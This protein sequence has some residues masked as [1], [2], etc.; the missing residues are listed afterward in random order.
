VSLEANTPAKLSRPRLFDMT[1]RHRLFARLDTGRAH[2]AIW[3]DGPA[4]AGKTSLLAGYVEARAVPACWYQVDGGDADVATFFYY[5]RAL[6]GLAASADLPAFSPEYLGDVPG[7]ARRYFRALFAQ[8]GAS[9]LLVL[10]NVQE[11]TG[12]PAFLA[13]LREAIGQVPAGVNLVLISRWE[14]PTAFAR[15]MALQSIVRIS[16]PELQLTA[17]ETAAIA[18]LDPG[19]DDARIGQLLEACGGWAAGLTLTLA[20]RTGSGGAAPGRSESL[21]AAFD[22]LAAEILDGADP[23]TRDFLLHTWPLPR[24][25]A[26]WARELTGLDGAERILAKL[27]QQNYFIER[28]PAP[29]PS[30]QYHGLFREFLAARARRSLPAEQIAELQRR[31][32]ALLEQAGENSEAFALRQASGEM[33]ECQR[34]I[35]AHA[36]QLAE[37][38][39]LQTLHGWIDALPKERCDNSPWLAY[40]RGICELGADPARARRSFATAADGFA[41]ANERLG[42]SKALAGLIDTCYAEWSD[43]S[44]LDPWIAQ[45]IALLDEDLPFARVEDGLQ[46]VAAALVALLYR[47]PTHP[48]LPELAARVHTRLGG[49]IAANERVAAGTYLLNC[50][51]WMGQ[52]GAAREVIALVSPQLDAAAVAPLR[53]A[54]WSV[55][56]AYHHYIAG[57]RQATLTSLEAAAQIA[58][59]H[60]QAVAENIVLL[61]ATFLHLSEGD[62]AAATQS[63]TAFERQ[64]DPGRRLDYAI[65]TYHRA[66]LALLAG[67]IDAALQFGGK[68]AKLAEQAGVPNVQGYFLLL[69]ALATAERGDHAAAL[70]A[71]TRGHGCT[72]PERFPIFE[73]T[74]QLVRA[75]LASRAA[76]DA[77]CDAALRAALAIGARHDYANNLLWLPG[78]MAHLCARALERN[79][80]TDYVRRLIRRRGLPPPGQDTI[81]WPWPLRISTLGALRVERDGEALPFSRKVQKRPLALLMA[82]VALGGQDISAGLLAEKLWPDAEGDAARAA[83][84]TALYRLRHLLDVD[85][86]ILLADGKLSLNG[87]RVWVDTQ[88]FE[89]LARELTAADHAPAAPAVE[90]LL[91]LYHGHFLE[92][93]E[94]APWMLGRREKLK[95]SLEHVL[96]I[97]G[98]RLE[99]AGQWDLAAQA[100]ERGIGL[101]MLAEPL[102]R[103]LMACQQRQGRPAQ[104]LETYRRCRQALSVVLGIPPSPE[105]EALRRSFD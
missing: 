17:E 52:T 37:Q 38:G 39:R 72:D 93:E 70:S 80:E 92:H 54:W 25:T 76:Q 59:E 27:F 87:K 65:A 6:P 89:R 98:R 71:W 88:A 97:V 83:L 99:E 32:A 14:P 69:V 4:G 33:A 91:A 24:L 23:E 55:R 16:W 31:G 8:L 79:I 13:V 43:F 18:G 60:G 10:D 5:L 66:W 22:F 44:M 42:S 12:S 68:A 2:P 95:A 94:E 51:N 19:A 103:R 82:L 21:E 3:V 84:G 40:W 29:E 78:V 105:T 85:D 1:P 30:Y 96:E 102:Y 11:A 57:E 58:R 47:Q 53:R 26:A 62:V 63:L 73:F 28:R 15:F 75:H 45:L 9:A 41:A 46:L 20:R 74:A 49:G 104:A 81:H 48:R 100:Y 64:L 86:A 36:E 90:Q 34:L 35:L 77:A 7:F 67:N 61:Y 56:L 101:D 50:Y